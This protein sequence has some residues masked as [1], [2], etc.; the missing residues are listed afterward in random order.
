MGHAARHLET[1]ECAAL[2]ATEPLRHKIP[3]EDFNTFQVVCVALAR[4]ASEGFGD[5]ALCCSLTDSGRIQEHSDVDTVGLGFEG[6]LPSLE[7]LLEQRR[8]VV[9]H[10]DDGH[11]GCTPS[12]ALRER[13]PVICKATFADV[14]RLVTNRSQIDKE[15]VADYAALF[16]KYVQLVKR[17][18]S[19]QTASSSTALTPVAPNPERITATEPLPSECE[20]QE[21]S[22]SSSKRGGPWWQSALP[23][24]VSEDVFVALC[25]AF[26]AN[27]FGVWRSNGNGEAA[28]LFPCSSFFNH[29]CAPNI[30]REM[31]GRTSLFFAAKPIRCG[32]AITLSYIDFK[33]PR[34]TRQ[35][36]LLATY[37]FVCRCPRCDDPDAIDHRDA[38]D[39]PLCLDCKSKVLRPL[40]SSSSSSANAVTANG[41]D[42]GGGGAAAAMSYRCPCC[43]Q[44]L[45]LHAL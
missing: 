17:K 9:H 5:K 22:S 18:K 14:Q 39:L 41:G 26:Q 30:G 38:Y 34:E 12:S 27:G 45:S 20:V 25:C 36:K 4:A 13:M 1:G 6:A 42:G 44:V 31:H 28:G 19:K 24:K 11:D 29:S 23:E 7:A 32:D 21:V 40:Y 15:I 16:P 35:A 8:V 43:W 37:S 3:K 2:A 10:D 33:L